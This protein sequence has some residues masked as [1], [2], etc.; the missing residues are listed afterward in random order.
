M[1]GSGLNRHSINATVNYSSSKRR[2]PLVRGWVIRL[3][4]LNT[5]YP[6]PDT[7]TCAYVPTA[8]ET[9]VTKYRNSPDVC[10]GAL[11]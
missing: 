5:R 2:A 3:F 11:L 9:Y 1:K 4:A 7:H 6:I 10:Y 8:R